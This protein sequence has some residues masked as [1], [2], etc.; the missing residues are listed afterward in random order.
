[1]VK[2]ERTVLVTTVELV[3]VLPGKT[4]VETLSD[5]TVLPGNVTVEK[6]VDPETTDVTTVV[7]GGS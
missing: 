7:T 1:M 5:V 4:K 6:T 2:V 3:M